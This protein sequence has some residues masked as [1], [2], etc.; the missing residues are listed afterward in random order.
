MSV[1]NLKVKLAKLVS[2]EP[3]GWM[4]EAIE[5][6]ENRAWLKRS[7]GIAIKVL[8]TL[9]EKGLS[10]KELAVALSVS[11]QQVNKIVKGGENLTLE[12]IS[13]LEVALAIQLIE[14][15]KVQKYTDA[16]KETITY[17]TTTELVPD[18]NSVIPVYEKQH[19][20]AAL[21]KMEY[22]AAKDKYSYTKDKAA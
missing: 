7:Q 15:V 22:D 3:S 11:P 21:F 16:H 1:T 18:I 4:E 8:R 5:R 14:V 20:K 9:R 12:T 13:K 10:Q 17:S 2:T 6:A 19:N